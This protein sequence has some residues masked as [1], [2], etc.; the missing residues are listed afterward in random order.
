[1]IDGETYAAS[2]S[3][4][5]RGELESAGPL[6]TGEFP[7]DIWISEDGYVVRMVMEIDGSQAEFEDGESFGSMRLTY[8]VFDINQPVEITAPTDFVDGSELSGAFGDLEG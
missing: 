3:D 2:L 5:E 8:D 7:M 6:P 1:V 4:E